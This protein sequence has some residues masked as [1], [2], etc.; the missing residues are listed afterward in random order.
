MTTPKLPSG[1]RRAFTLIELLTVIAIIGILAAIIIP[2]V[3]TVRQTA[4]ESQN[5]S[6]LRQLGQMMIVYS[7]DHKGRFPAGWIDSSSTS[8]VDRLAPYF[9]G[10]VENNKRVIGELTKS[11]TAKLPSTSAHP[12]HY[13]VHDALCNDPGHAQ[14]AVA[15]LRSGISIARPTQVILI[16]DG[17]QSEAGGNT[18]ASFW[19]PYE[20]A[21]NNARAL[22]EL[23]PYSASNDRDD[24][25]GRG[26]LRYRNRDKVHATHV[27]GST[28]AY[29]A[30]TVTFGNVIF[31]R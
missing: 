20:M 16:A 17:P 22:N 11:P 23:I 25:S 28:K 14:A 1:T 31:T 26:R 24:A 3:G 5:L 9:N 8:W 29:R 6:N 18:V 15:A 12:V 13:V 2:T 30:G 7:N 19:H 10:P 21:F 4:R 27:D